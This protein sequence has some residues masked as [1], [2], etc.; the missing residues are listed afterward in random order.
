MWTTVSFV[1]PL[2]FESGEALAISDAIFGWG[3][4]IYPATV[5]RPEPDAAERQVFV[6]EANSPFR[7]AATARC[8]RAG[9]VAP[10]TTSCGTLVVIE[11]R[12]R[13]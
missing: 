5:P 13:P 9:G 10:L 2:L 8:A 12:L 3:R 7:E 1:Y 4:P 11:E 6:L